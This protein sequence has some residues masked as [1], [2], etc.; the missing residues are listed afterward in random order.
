MSKRRDTK[1]PPESDKPANDRPNGAT[2][3]APASDAAEQEENAKLNMEAAVVAGHAA[4]LRDVAGAAYL[5]GT[6]EAAFGG[7]IGADAFQAYR[8]QLLVDC[9]SPKDPLVQMM[10]EQMAMAHHN[11]GRLFAISAQSKSWGE[12]TALVATAARLMGE[13]RRSMLALEEY[14][15]KA[16][17][18]S[19]NSSQAA[20]AA[21]TNGKAAG[22]VKRK[23]RKPRRPSTGK[24]TSHNELASK[25]ELPECLKNRMR[26]QIPVASQ[27]GGGTNGNGEG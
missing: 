10:I 24:E 14:R 13:Y 19:D 18:A 6:L 8:D 11:A 9:G 4:N 7:R 23:R 12:N 15:R 16:T 22:K 27:P 25:A 21:Q 3:A 5:C 1:S 20:S 2:T 26:G 17:P